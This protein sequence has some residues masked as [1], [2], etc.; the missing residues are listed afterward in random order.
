[1]KRI[2]SILVLSALCACC[3]FG[4]A[5]CDSGNVS[6]H[7]YNAAVT[8]PTCAEQGYT[9]YTC[10]RC[11]DSYIDD[12]T[13]A[14]G[15]NY[16][17]TRTKQPTATEKGEETGVCSRC[18][19]TITR[20]I[21]ELDHEHNYTETVIPPT[22][23]DQGYTTYTCTICGYSYIDD[24]NDELGHTYSNGVCTR[25]GALQPID[26][27]YFTFTL[28]SDDTYEIKAKDT[29][30][31]PAEVILPSTYNGKPVTSIGYE[32]FA[33]CRSLTSIDIP[34]S[35]TSI[36]EGAFYNCYSLTSITIPDSVTSIGG[37]AFY[38]CPCIKTNKGLS[39]VDK[40]L[41]YADRNIT[42]ATIKDDTVG[43]ADYAFDG[44]SSLTS[45]TIPDSVTSIGDYAFAWWSSLT[46][47]NVSANNMNYK[48][49][50]GNLYCKD[51]KTLIQYAMGKTATTFTI[52]DSVTSIGEAAFYYCSSLTSIVVPDSVT[53]IGD[54]AFAACSS[55]TSIVIP[56]SVTSI[57][58]GAFIACRS[59]TSIVIPDSVTSIGDAAF[60][61]CSGLQYNEYDNGLYLGNSNN[62][63]LALI[64][65]KS[66]EITSCNIHNDTKV[67]AGSAFSS[68]RSLTSI[69]IP[70]S[71][72]SIGG[73]AFENCSGLTSITFNGTK[74]QWGAIEK[75]E[76]WHDCVPA[77]VVKCTNGDSAI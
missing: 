61:G 2:I 58:D 39:Y 38:D 52:P 16:E 6:G 20:E 29:N 17:W 46:S 3:A 73:W 15:H 47:I 33:D 43:I 60:A 25:C 53:S 65:A 7:D 68:C 69:V 72:T 64:K 71:V 54:G 55:L 19:D 41:I 22:C 76:Y 56:D 1:M 42:S 32:A 34:D 23:T 40:W 11:G 28:L 50:D 74:A 49:I 10:S 77:T 63:Y 4:F 14:L 48:S 44:C 51:G 45:I 36:R 9:T 57:G 5:A 24:Y 75:D 18:G 62:P 13:D 27:G 66:Q 8:A 31:M 12:E 26:D 21:P 59:L 67:V 37:S 30:N 35:V 70:D